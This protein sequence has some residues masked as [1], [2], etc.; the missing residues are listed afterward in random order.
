MTTCRQESETMAHAT[1][2]L[3][4]RELLKRRDDTPR[5]SSLV[6]HALDK[7]IEALAS[8]NV[9]LA[10]EI[11]ANDRAVLGNRLMNPPLI[12]DLAHGISFCSPL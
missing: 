5:L 6:I 9:F 3:L 1:R 8:R 2:S 10:R 4:D 11:I 7:A 12:S